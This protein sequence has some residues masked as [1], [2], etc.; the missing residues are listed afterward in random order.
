MQDYYNM[1]QTILSINLDYS[2]EENHPA[3]YINSLVESLKLK[4]QYQFGRPREYDLSAMLKLVLLA[5][6]YGIFSSRKI[7]RFARENKPAAWLVADQVPSYRTIC[8]FRISQE[9][10][11]LTKK[12]LDALTK[13]FRENGLIDDITF[14]DGTKILADANKYSFVWKKNTIRYDEMNRE[15]LTK[16]LG[17]LHTAK[18]IDKIPEGS[19]LTPELLDII[20]GKVEDH[21]VMLDAKIESSKKGRPNPAKKERRTIRSKHKK[22]VSSRDKLAEHQEQMDIYQDRSSYSKTDHDATFMRAKEDP[23]KNAPLKPGFNLQLATNNQFILGFQI[24]QN[25]ADTRTLIPFIETLKENRVLGATIVADAGYASESNYRYL[26]D[27]L[28]Q[29]STLIPYGTMLRENSRKW[30]SD[31]SKVMNWDYYDQDDY[32]IDPKG[33]RFNFN[34][35]RHRTDKRGFT[36]DFKEYVAEQYDE[37]HEVIKKALTPKGYLR[38]IEVN[39]D[40]EYF[41]AQQRELLSSPKTSSIYARRQIDVEPVFGRMKASLGFTKFSVRGKD[42]VS[43]E[44]GIVAI[45]LNILKL[46]SLRAASNKKEVRKKLRKT[47]IRFFATF[48]IIFNILGSYVTT[49]R[50]VSETI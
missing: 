12:S 10:A 41:K 28:G 20:I 42:K 29:G 15:K 30:K 22:L 24:F 34:A 1:D 35:Y 6:S 49:S 45:A 48:S 18:V 44:I 47:K 14:I 23:M 2:P 33:V 21:L 38:R 37:N 7:E 27:E 19:D 17:E 8:R 40:W 50:P 16:L 39:E 32:F 3:I 9:L 25:P 43:K 13:F 26:E 36:R 5:Y 11:D 4:H 46:V 31:D